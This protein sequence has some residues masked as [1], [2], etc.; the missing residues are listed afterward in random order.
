MIISVE[1]KGSI[2]HGSVP[3]QGG[4]TILHVFCPKHLTFEQSFFSSS[5]FLGAES[6]NDFFLNILVNDLCLA[7]I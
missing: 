4:G 7:T 6:E 2:S 5:F 3:I 1:H